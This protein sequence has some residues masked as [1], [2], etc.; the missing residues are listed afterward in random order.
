M[1]ATPSTKSKKSPTKT[2]KNVITRLHTDDEESLTETGNEP[3]EIGLLAQASR[4]VT[5]QQL[6]DS[7]EQLTAL[8]E[9]D[10]QHLNQLEE[11]IETGLETFRAVGAALL[12]IRQQKLYRATHLRFSDYLQEKYNLGRKRAYQIMGAATLVAELA[13]EA[14]RQADISGD[15]PFELPHKESHASA[16]AELPVEKRAQV[17]QEVSRD[18]QESRRPVTAEKIHQKA[19]AHGV[20]RNKKAP[21]DRKP[22]QARPADDEEF[23]PEQ[24]AL[25]V[26]AMNTGRNQNGEDDQTTWLSPVV[27]TVAGT[28]P[29]DTRHPDAEPYFIQGATET[30]PP[31]PN[32]VAGKLSSTDLAHQI[33][34]A[35]QRAQLGD[36]VLVIRGNFLIRHGLEAA[37]KTERQYDEDIT[38]TFSETLTLNEAREYGFID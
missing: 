27:S 20:P 5:A 23:G 30:D 2:F 38:E 12:E 8:S 33:R 26:A 11:V 31:E 37:W 7:V 18:A 14:Q 13:T 4:S 21:K 1:N 29:P 24:V 35:S 28:S 15:V 25:T 6:E 9:D 17:W 3:P 10:Q 36:M 32:A 22:R 19:E 16:L 34:Q